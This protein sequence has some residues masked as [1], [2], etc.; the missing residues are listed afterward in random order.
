MGARF[1]LCL[2]NVRELS[3]STRGSALVFQGVG[4]SHYKMLGRKN[5]GSSVT[6]CFPAPFAPG[7]HRRGGTI[8]SQALLGYSQATLHTGVGRRSLVWKILSGARLSR[9][10][11]HCSVKIL[12]R[13]MRVI[14]ARSNSFIPSK[15]KTTPVPKGRNVVQ[16]KSEI[17]PSWRDSQAFQGVFAFLTFSYGNGGTKSSKKWRNGATMWAIVSI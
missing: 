11:K 15:C 13:P 8:V 2:D 9:R 3:A 14:V 7:L 16:E 5:P 1:R 12:Q 6:V 17:S 4:E 10:R